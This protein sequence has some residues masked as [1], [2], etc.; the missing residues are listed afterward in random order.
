MNAGSSATLV[1]LALLDAPAG[2]RE[3]RQD[4]EG[5]P[6]TAR[7]VRARVEGDRRFDMSSSI[8][9]AALSTRSTIRSGDSCVTA[10][11]GRVWTPYERAHSESNSRS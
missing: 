2:A 11:G 4:K 9:P 8:A 3:A 6:S 10:S 5:P 7:H 1:K